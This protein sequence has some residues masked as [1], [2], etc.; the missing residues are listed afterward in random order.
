MYTRASTSR[1][2]IWFNRYFVSFNFFFLTLLYEIYFFIGTQT[3]KIFHARFFRMDKCAHQCNVTFKEERARD[4]SE[5]Q[6]CLILVNIV[7]LFTAV[8][9]W[10]L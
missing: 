3:T 7:E 2:I 9:H 5:K 4:L 8:Q 6:K 10:H 1:V